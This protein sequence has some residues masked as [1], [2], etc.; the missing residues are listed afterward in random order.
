MGSIDL[1]DLSSHWDTNSEHLPQISTD[2]P[3][4]SQEQ[5][6]KQFRTHARALNLL[7]WGAIS[8]FFYI[9]DAMLA[10]FDEIERVQRREISRAM[11]NCP[12]HPHRHGKRVLRE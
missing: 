3:L 8:V 7:V 1:K 9:V 10:E 2:F 5:L 12:Y 6:F 11:R 4:R